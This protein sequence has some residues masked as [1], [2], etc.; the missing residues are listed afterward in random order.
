LPGALTAAVPAAAG[1]LEQCR[2]AILA[3]F[4]KHAFDGSGADNF[5][6]AV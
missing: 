2:K 5:F 1:G 6:D 4:C 3:D